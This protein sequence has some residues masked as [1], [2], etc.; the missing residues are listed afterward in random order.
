MAA[1]RPR[2]EGGGSGSDQ[3]VADPLDALSKSLQATIEKIDQVDNCID[4]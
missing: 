2:D 3:L 1:K 4:E